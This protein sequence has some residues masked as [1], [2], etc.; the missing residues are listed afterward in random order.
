MSFHL[1]IWVDPISA[2]G[3]VDHGIEGRSSKDRNIKRVDPAE[4]Q[5][6]LTYA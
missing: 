3:F 2:S 1:C 6:P 5:S 4:S